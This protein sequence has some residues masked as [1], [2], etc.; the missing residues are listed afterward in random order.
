MIEQEE[1]RVIC[2]GC[3]TGNYFLCNSFPGQAKSHAQYEIDYAKAKKKSKD[4]KAQAESDIF[5]K[6]KRNFRKDDVE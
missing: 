4:R 6:S 5:P 3:R 1:K 2:E